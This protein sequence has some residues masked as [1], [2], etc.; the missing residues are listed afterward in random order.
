MLWTP[1]VLDFIEAIAVFCGDGLDEERTLI[2]DGKSSCE[3]RLIHRVLV[4]PPQMCAVPSAAGFDAA[5]APRRGATED[6]VLHGNHPTV[7]SALYLRG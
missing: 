3:E 4:I 2:H 6:V 7:C 1:F 5:V